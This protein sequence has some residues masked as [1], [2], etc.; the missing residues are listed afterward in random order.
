MLFMC[1]AFKTLK[2]KVSMNLKQSFVLFFILRFGE[3]TILI[4]QNCST[5]EQYTYLPILYE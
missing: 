4:D 5:S 2:L 1:A 3:S